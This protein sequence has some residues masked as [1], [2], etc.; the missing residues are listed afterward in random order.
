MMDS[1]LNDT[2]LTR[3]IMTSMMKTMNLL[4]GLGV[5]QFIVVLAVIVFW[6]DKREKKNKK[7]LTLFTMISAIV[8]ENIIFLTVTTNVILLFIL[9]TMKASAKSTDY[10]IFFSLTYFFSALASLGTLRI[11]K[12]FFLK[13]RGNVK[14]KNRL[15]F[16]HY[17]L[18]SSIVLILSFSLTYFLFPKPFL[19]LASAYCLTFFIVHLISLLLQKINFDKQQKIASQNKKKRKKKK[20]KNHS[21]RN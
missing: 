7:V 20:H 11:I 9:A 18:S 17:L 1:L 12:K 5:L 2:V 4:L 19:S 6:L 14:K 21:K 3:P 13:K 16:Y 10:L 8:A 15:T